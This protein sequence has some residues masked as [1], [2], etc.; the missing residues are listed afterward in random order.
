[1]AL[2]EAV[3][4]RDGGEAPGA[5]RAGVS[6]HDWESWRRRS[7][8]RSSTR[9]VAT[10]S[11]S[12]GDS[13]SA[14]PP[15]PRL[16]ASLDAREGRAPDRSGGFGAWVQER[17]ASWGRALGRCLWACVAAAV[18]AVGECS[19]AWHA[20]AAGRAA[21]REASSRG[22]SGPG[23]GDAG[24]G[25][26]TVRDAVIAE[27][28]ALAAGRARI[29]PDEAA[30]WGSAGA[31]GAAAQVRGARSAATR[32]AVRRHARQAQAFLV[33]NPTLLSAEG[34]ATGEA[35]D[36]LVEA[37]ITAR[38]EPELTTW[39]PCAGMGRG[40]NPRIGGVLRA[41]LE[42][43]GYAR[44][45]TWPLSRATARALGGDDGEDDAAHA[46]P[47][48]VWE[49]IHGIR[50]SD[51]GNVWDEC[52]VALLTTIALAARRRGAATG[53]I[54]GQTR[55]VGPAA[56][57]I[58][59]RQRAK[60]QAERAGGRPRRQ[61]RPV[62][63]AHWL[64]REF[65][66]PWLQWHARRQ[67]PATARVFPSITREQP[68]GAGAEKAFRVGGMWVHPTRSWSDRQL[69]AA[70]D[71]FIAGCAGRSVQGLRAGNNIE[72]RRHRDAVS[73]VTRRTLHE[74]TV[75]DLIGSERA[76]NEVFA[77]D[78]AAATALLG[79]LRIERSAQGLL[80]ATARNDTAGED[81]RRWEPLHAAEGGLDDHGDAA[82]GA[83][84]SDDSSASADDEESSSGDES[85]SD[86]VVGDG[87]RDTREVD[88][89]LCGLRMGPQDYGFLCEECDWAACPSCHPG[90][91]AVELRCP[92]HRHPADPFTG[93]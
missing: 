80:R 81:P 49:L 33:A 30:L 26:G 47:V 19:R 55:V 27:L 87:G 8:T 22:D 10:S 38:C 35:Y 37:W 16:A 12:G 60:Q 77:E 13:W 61:A 72:L 58:S 36:V 68:R 4:R 15:A 88:C 79:T 45:S 57:E 65:V 32:A 70:C 78:F 93:S 17:L 91:D 48:F 83:D 25:S 39:R 28:G 67:S 18:W 21:T 92:R 7:R 62:V 76:Y 11:S 54:V 69:R 89:G 46:V 9:Q 63:V 3:R 23:D 43:G 20:G 82:Q 84:P 71:R 42:R 31:A 85:V 52:A 86:A 44:G 41:G 2:R 5:A 1:M 75:K 29:T 34:A 64:V 14:G 40:R 73:D 51:V 24:R 66:V 56:V 59:P 50:A 90:G 6:H 74:R 53:L